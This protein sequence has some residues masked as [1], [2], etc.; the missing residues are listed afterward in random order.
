MEEPIVYVGA[1]QESFIA[2]RRIMV[3][4]F[5]WAAQGNVFYLEQPTSNVIRT[6][7]STLYKECELAPRYS[8]DS[9]NI[10]DPEKKPDYY[11]V[12][13]EIFPGQHVKLD[14]DLGMDPKNLEKV[15][16]KRINSSDALSRFYYDDGLEPPAHSRGLIGNTGHFSFSKDDQFPKDLKG[17]EGSSCRLMPRRFLFPDTTS[18]LQEISAAQEKSINCPDENNPEDTLI[19]DGSSTLSAIAHAFKNDYYSDV[20]ST[21]VSWQMTYNISHLLGMK[22]QPFSA[23]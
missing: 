12:T 7:H 9:E 4:N 5:Y 18:R 23:G 13:A 22:Y 21:A 1:D 2:M 3:A 8:V 11:T 20:I 19:Y 16:R 17:K 14:A 15:V 10:F 6:R